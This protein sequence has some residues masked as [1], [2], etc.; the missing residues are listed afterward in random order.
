METRR[1]ARDLPVGIF[2][3]P[4]IGLAIK[5]KPY[6]LLKE[7]PLP[8]LATGVPPT[9]AG[10]PISVLQAASSANQLPGLNVSKGRSWGVEAGLK[11]MAITPEVGFTLSFALIETIGMIMPP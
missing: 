7:P 2:A 5:V 1:I 8:A 11:L 4:I 10:E 3:I 6:W 9:P